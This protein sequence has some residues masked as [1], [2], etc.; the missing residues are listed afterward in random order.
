MPRPSYL[1][2]I[3]HS[4]C[5]DGYISNVYCNLHDPFTTSAM[6]NIFSM[7]RLTQPPSVHIVII[8][9]LHILHSPLTSP[10][11]DTS[12]PLSN[13]SQTFLHAPFQVLRTPHA[14]LASHLT[15]GLCSVSILTYKTSQH[16]MQ[17]LKK[18]RIY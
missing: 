3:L 10:F 8:I 16:N 2:F 9:I 12:I 18:F 17:T 13:F 15:A 14:R 6:R 11:S 5:S 7:P 4:T 1:Q